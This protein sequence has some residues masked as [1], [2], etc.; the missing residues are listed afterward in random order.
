MNR[1]LRD[2]L[3]LAAI[4]LCAGG[5]YVWRHRREPERPP[6]VA[7]EP[8][9]DVPASRIVP[10]RPGADGILVQKE[11]LLNPDLRLNKDQPLRPRPIGSTAQL[12]SGGGAAPAAPETTAA[13]REQAEKLAAA[14]S[15]WL[16]KAASPGALACVAVVF[17]ACYLALSRGLSRGPGTGGFTND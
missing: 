10:P 5:F 1:L 8:R 3:A 13:Q 4:A 7:G 15:P 12:I 11:G 14:R 6:L 16:D 2:V 17:A 9:L